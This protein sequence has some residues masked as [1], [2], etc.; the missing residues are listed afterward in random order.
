MDMMN[1]YGLTLLG[2]SHGHDEYLWFNSFRSFS[3]T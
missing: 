1:I 2:V 3:W